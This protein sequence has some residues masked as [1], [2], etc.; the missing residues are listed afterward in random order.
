M[1]VAESQPIKSMARVYLSTMSIFLISFALAG[2]CHASGVRMV[3]D[4]AVPIYSDWL[5]K[6]FLSEDVK[7]L[8][9]AHVGQDVDTDANVGG[10]HCGL[11]NV[12]SNIGVKLVAEV[13][14]GS[15]SHYTYEGYDDYGMGK[16]SES[17]DQNGEPGYNVLHLRA[18]AF[19]PVYR[20]KT[21]PFFV[22]ALAG[23]ALYRW[24][25][26]DCIGDFCDD[27]E[28]TMNLG[29]GMYYGILGLE[30]FTNVSGDVPDL[31]MRLAVTFP[32]GKE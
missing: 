10:A 16:T 30:A 25:G 2:C 5:C 26:S 21:Q 24:S 27:T 14:Y 6:S 7:Y 32:L 17:R 23:P 18:N 12:V 9:G 13:G 22:Y 20:S 11:P 31:G 15:Q 8:A 1:S 29:G 28:Y 4:E 3:G 19:Y